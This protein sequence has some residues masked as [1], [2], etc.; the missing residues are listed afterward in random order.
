MP[1][2]GGQ[3]LGSGTMMVSAAAESHP[4][5]NNIHGEARDVDAGRLAICYLS[6][7]AAG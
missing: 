7:D 4:G 5:A 1:L 2:G 6:A 3:V